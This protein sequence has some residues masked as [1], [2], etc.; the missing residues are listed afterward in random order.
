MREEDDDED[1]AGAPDTT[2]DAILAH[3]LAEEL[4]R[5]QYAK[6]QFSDGRGSRAQH[7]RMAKNQQ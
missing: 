4:N 7:C 5:E 2:H 6:V 1:E 3:Q